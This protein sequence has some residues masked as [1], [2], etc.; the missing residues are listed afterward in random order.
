MYI[1][2]YFLAATQS[3]T[4]IF[5]ACSIYSLAAAKFFEAALPGSSRPYAGAAELLLL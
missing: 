4:Q 1:C 2:I 5:L 3:F